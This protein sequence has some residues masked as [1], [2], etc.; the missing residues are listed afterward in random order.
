MKRSRAASAACA[1]ITLATC[2]SNSKV[3][4]Y[5]HAP[6]AIQVAVGENRYSIDPGRSLTF[7]YPVK[8]SGIVTICF[9]RALARYPVLYL[10]R[11]YLSAGLLRGTIRVQF[12]SDARIRILKPDE[13]FPLAPD[14]PQPT[15]YPLT[16]EHEGDC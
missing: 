16:P 6:S 8:D 2:S 3:E 5:N 11:E 1:A 13:E 7:Y 12:D 9:G 4:L 10:Y 15:H 14:R